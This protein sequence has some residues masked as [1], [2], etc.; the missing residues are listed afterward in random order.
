VKSYHTD[1]SNQGSFKK[2]SS[3]YWSLEN[4]KLNYW[5]MSRNNILRWLAFLGFLRQVKLEATPMTSIK[6]ILKN[7][8]DVSVTGKQMLII[9]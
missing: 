6:T 1:D 7:I 8:I 5:M 4:K 2:I 9:G 3:T